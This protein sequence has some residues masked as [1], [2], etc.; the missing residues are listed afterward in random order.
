MIAG[1]K[2]LH[3]LDALQ[4]ARD[5][6]DRGALGVD[7]GRNIFQ[8]DTPMAMMKAVRKVVHEKFTAKRAFDYYKELS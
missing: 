4:M 3:V 7:M 6:I 8:S 2:K 1:G 5:A